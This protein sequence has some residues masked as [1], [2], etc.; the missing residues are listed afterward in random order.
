MRL[1]LAATFANLPFGTIYAF[2]V[3][4]KSMESML[5]LTRSDMGTVFGLS[6]VMFATGM[7]I[8]PVMYSRLSTG[9]VLISTSVTGAIGLTLAS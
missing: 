2:S 7:N 5:G 6:T 4:L 8:A 3:F 9:A 1:I